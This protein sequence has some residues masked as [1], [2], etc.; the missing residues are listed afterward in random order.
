[1]MY[2]AV[3]LSTAPTGSSLFAAQSGQAL[4]FGIA[5]LGLMD[6][7]PFVFVAT[8]FLSSS[9]GLF[10]ST[11][12]M[13]AAPSTNVGL[14]YHK[15]PTQRLPWF[16]RCFRLPT[17]TDSAQ[18]SPV[19]APAIAL[20][21]WQ[22]LLVEVSHLSSCSSRSE[23]CLMPNAQSKVSSARHLAVILE[24]SVRFEGRWMRSSVGILIWTVIIAAEH[25]CLLR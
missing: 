4:T 1:M 23:H 25:N 21:S 7:C 8:A 2:R 17:V 6:I 3:M 16:P 15:S 18:T 19:A 13:S 24:S 20:T 9:S 12:V 14:V 11:L 10:R 5:C 22:R